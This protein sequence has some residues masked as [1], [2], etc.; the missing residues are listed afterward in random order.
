M[1]KRIPTWIIDIDHIADESARPGSNA[2]AVGL[3]GP[4]GYEGDGSELTH[5]FRMLDDDREVYYEGRASRGGTFDP[6]DDFGE[7]NAGAT[8]IQYWQAGGGW[9]NL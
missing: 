4:R 9:Q 7:P 1:N 8:T 6:L 5:K 2:N 3:C